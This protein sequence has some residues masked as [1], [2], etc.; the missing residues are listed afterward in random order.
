VVSGAGKGFNE[1]KQGEYL[2]AIKSFSEAG[3]Q[4]LQIVAGATKALAD[5]GKLA[6]YT[7]KALKFADFAAKLAP[8]L[9]LIANSAS[10]V[11]HMASAKETKNAGYAVAALGD[12]LGVLGSAVGLI[13]GGQP[14]GAIV[15]GIGTI[16]SAGGEFFGNLQDRQDFAEEQKRLL[17]A[18]K[19]PKD[20]QDELLGANGDRVRELANDL[21]LNGAQ[22]QDLLRTYPNLLE[23]TGRGVVLDNFK[24]MVGSLALNPNQV[25]DLF[26]S[27]GKGL[28]DQKAALEGFF[29]RLSRDLYPKNGQE[30]LNAIHQIATDPRNSDGLRQVFGNVDRYLQS[31]IQGPPAPRNS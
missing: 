1:V 18:A 29:S 13:P 19:V 21:K 16:I 2:K 17:D 23:G 7:G 10:F 20:L 6:Q 3:D 26:K 31:Q 9:G 24:K 12:A 15:G 5:T 11:D 25:V 8:G 30:W 27:I 22:I 14:A 28:P 4:G